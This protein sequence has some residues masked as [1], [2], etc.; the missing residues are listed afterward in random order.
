[1]GGA[2][3]RDTRVVDCEKD[4]G[5]IEVLDCS[6]MAVG[7]IPQLGID[8]PSFQ[9]GRPLEDRLKGL[10]PQTIPAMMILHQRV[11]ISVIGLMLAVTVH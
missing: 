7:Q 10:W 2:E 5:E 6:D 1:M 4:L 3:T 8:L 9:I 11:V